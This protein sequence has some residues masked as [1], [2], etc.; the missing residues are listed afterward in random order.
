MLIL[1]TLPSTIF[2]SLLDL[3][4][5]PRDVPMP[6]I[7]VPLAILSTISL[8]GSLAI[9][10]FR[11]RRIF[12]PIE[13]QQTKWIVVALSIGFLPIMIA[14]LA[15]LHYW[16]SHQIEKSMIVDFIASVIAT[17]MMILIVLGILFSIFR[18]RLYDVDI[19]VSRALVYSALTGILAMVGFVTTVFLDYALK[20]TFGNQT[21]LLTAIASAV[22]IA[23]LFNPVREQLQKVVDRRFKQE[24]MDFENTFIEFTSELS[25]LFTKEELSTHLS[26]HAVEQLDVA[27]ASVFLNGPNGTLKP[28]NTTSVEAEPMQPALDDKIVEKIQNGQLVSPDGDSAQSLVVPLVVPRS[29]KPSLIGALILGRRLQGLGYS[30]TMLKSLKKFGEQVGKAFYIAEV[31]GNHKE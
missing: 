24:E 2:Y 27:Y 4:I 7:T 14:A 30:T 15:S 1:L 28:V 21:G 6:G 12:S 29:R 25:S 31:K 10:L 9:I 16:G 11:Y 19:F 5:F 17:L 23:A 20:Q 3:G 22:P 18:Y 13:R 26:R 8:L